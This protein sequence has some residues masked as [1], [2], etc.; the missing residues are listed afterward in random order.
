[1]TVMTRVLGVVVAAAA[2]TA[3]AG[4][5]AGVAK[6]ARPTLTEIDLGTLGGTFSEAV[7]VNASGQVVGDSTTAAPG[8]RHAFSWTR[9]GGMVDLGTLGGSFS[10]A[11]AVNDG[12]QVVGSS[13]IAGTPSSP[14]RSPGHGRAGWSTSAP[15]APAS[16][17]PLR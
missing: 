4:A 13:A 7:A 17:L 11:A 10:F 5:P 1:M 2:L 3:G 6:A 15:S 14:M 12:G 8:E 16:T 9:A